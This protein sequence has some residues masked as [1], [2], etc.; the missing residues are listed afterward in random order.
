M[1]AGQLPAFFPQ[2]AGRNS[3]SEHD[4][5][6]SMQQPYLTTMPHKHPHAVG[7]PITHT[8][9]AHECRGSSS[10]A[11]VVATNHHPVTIGQ[12]QCQTN[13]PPPTTHTSLWLRLGTF[14]TQSCKHHTCTCTTAF[15]ARHR[16]WAQTAPARQHSPRCHCCC[17]TPLTAPFAPIHRASRAPAKCES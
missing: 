2:P 17:C 9:S 1:T 14:S 13:P 16:G 4:H 12:M 11:C 7:Q 6:A 15:H 3:T 8:A 10:L 5:T